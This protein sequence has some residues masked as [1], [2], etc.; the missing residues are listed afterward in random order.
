[1]RQRAFY[2]TSGRERAVIIRKDQ[3]DG[4]E[5]SA[6][7]DFVLKLEQFLRREAPRMTAGL[8]D[9]ALHRFSVNCTR[10]GLDH[11][12]DKQK[13]IAQLALCFLKMNVDLDTRMPPVWVTQ[14]RDE[15]KM[16][17]DDQWLQYI[18]QGSRVQLSQE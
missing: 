3:M 9:P 1:M 4:Y 10:F 2:G 5:D 6:F 17:D 11:R 18:R 7:N 13:H 12:L 15:G 8:D 14:P 16:S